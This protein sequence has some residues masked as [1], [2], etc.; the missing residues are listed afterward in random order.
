MS[1]PKKQVAEII[2]DV[3]APVLSGGSIAAAAV[4]AILTSRDLLSPPPASQRTAPPSSSVQAQAFAPP[5]GAQVMNDDGT[6]AET[7]GSIGAHPAGRAPHL[8]SSNDQPIIVSLAKSARPHTSLAASHGQ[9]ASVSVATPSAAM[10][11]I[12]QNNGPGG[13]IVAAMRS[14]SEVGALAGT[15]DEAARTAAEKQLRTALVQKTGIGNANP[16]GLVSDSILTGTPGDD[17]LKGGE[18]DDT[19]SG[20]AGDDVLTGHGGDDLIDAGD[21]DDTLIGGAGDDRLSGGAG[22]DKLIGGEG[23]DTLD[24][25]AGNDRILAGDEDSV[26]GGAGDDRIEVAAEGGPARSVDGGDGD[27]TLVLSGARAG[28]LGRTAVSNVEH[29]VVES[30]DWALGANQPYVDI[31]VKSGAR[32]TDAILLKGS[33]RLVVEAGGAVGAGDGMGV[34]TTGSLTGA[35]IDNSGLITGISYNYFGPIG[36]GP[37]TIVNRV[38]GVIKSPENTGAALKLAGE[39]AQTAPAIANHGS[40]IGSDH[41]SS[42]AIDFESVTGTGARILNEAGGVI[43]TV[44]YQDVIRGGTG[45]VVENHGTIRSYRDHVAEDGTVRHGGDA[46]DYK[47]KTGGLVHNYGGGLIE[48]SRHAVTGKKG[49]TVINDAG[50][51]MIGRNGSALNMD[52]DAA[53]ANTARVTNHGLMEGRSA[54]YDDSDGDAIDTDGLLQLDNWGRIAGLGAHGSHD[55]EANVA[56]G[57]AMGGGAITNHVGATIYGWGRAIQVDD[58]ANGGALAAATIYNDGT[59]QGDGHGPAGV[60]AD[61]A[62]LFAARL[63][64]GEAINIVGGFA[65]D[66]TNSA[67]GKIIGGIRLDAGDDN[68][69]NA[70][71]ITATGGS[72]I[73]M[74]SGD[75]RITN[76]GT[77]TGAVSTGDGDDRI[78]NSGTIQG[79]VQLGSGSNTL[80]NAGTIAGDVAGGS[81]VDEITL[82]SGSTTVGTV[83]LGEGSDTLTI[84]AGASLKTKAASAVREPAKVADIPAFSQA[85]GGILVK[86]NTAQSTVVKSYSLVYD[87]LVKAGVQSYF[88]FLQTDLTNRSDEDLCLKAKDPKFGGIGINGDYEGQLT[89]GAW[90][91]V[92]FTITDR[93]DSVLIKKYIDGVFVGETVQSGANYARYQLDMSK[94]ILL[95]ADE[96]GETSKGAA[97]RF[98]F[99]DTVLSDA[100]IKALG[101]A[102]SDPILK[103]PPSKNSVQ[104]DFGTAG[105]SDI[106][107]QGSAS[108]SKSRGASDWGKNTQS[109]EALG[110]PELKSTTA[111][112]IVDAYGKAVDTG[113][114]NDKLSNSGTV[115]GDVDMGAGDDALSITA[116]GSITGGA[117]MGTGKDTLTNAGSMV[118]KGGPAVDMGAG[119]DTLD[120]GGTIT[121][122]VL[123]GEGDDKLINTGTIKGL[124]SLGAG[125]DELTN[126]GL[127]EGA[128]HAVTATGGAMIINDSAGTLSARN[129]SAISATNAAGAAVHVTNRGKIE[130]RTAD[131][132]DGDA[133]AAID[134]SGLADI[135][136]SGSIQKFFSWSHSRSG[137]ATAISIGGGVIR[138]AQGATIYA[139]GRAIAVDDTKGGAAL[140]ATRII[141]DGT[142]SADGRGG[143]GV[144]GDSR[145]Y[146]RE[147]INLIGD[148]ND[149]ITN[150]ATGRINAG[151]AMGGGDDKLENAGSIIANGLWAVDMGDG[152]DSIANTGS[153][154]GRIVLG[155]GNDTI[156][157]RRQINGSINGG[158]GAD[159]L[160]NSGTIEYWATSAVDLGDGNDRLE[161]GGRINGKVLTGAGDDFVT[162][163][164]SIAAGWGVAIEMGD[165]DDKLTLSGTI[166]GQVFMGAGNDTAIVEAGGSISGAI[167]G[168]DGVDRLVNGGRIEAVQAVTEFAV[169]LGAGDDV[170]NNSG[171]IK[172][173]VTTGDGA[174]EVINTSTGAIIGLVLMEAGNDQLGNSGKITATTGA[175]IDMGDGDDVVKLYIGSDIRGAILLGAGNDRLTADTYL[176][177]AIDVDAGDGNDEVYSALGDDIIHGG[178]GNDTVY[179]GDGADKLYGDAG[180]DVLHGEAGDDVLDGGAGDDVIDGGAGNDTIDGGDGEDMLDFSSASGRISVDFR[181]GTASGD[182]IGID[183][184]SHIEQARLGAQGGQID[185]G[186]GNET[187]FGGGGS[188]VLNGGAGDDRL[189][190][191]SAVN[192]LSGGSGNDTLIAGDKG[193]TLSGGSGD[194]RLNGGAGNDTI[195]GGS[196]RDV[197]TGGA[198]DDVLTGGSGQ[199]N[200][201][202]G[203]GSGRDRITDFKASGADH[204]LISFDH[205]FADFAAAMASARQVGA[206]VVFTIDDHTSLTL[207]QTQI[208][209]LSADDFRFS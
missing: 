161:N 138:N 63:K 153:I 118:A 105:W 98:L 39:L 190:G 3:V 112:P 24:G 97:A 25:G 15:S 9:S 140:A 64:G 172:G 103:T 160:K 92:A 108:V 150:G 61:T 40:I 148:W 156:E 23:Q 109:T 141:N 185:G 124:V 207:A 120:N 1:N 194:D 193:D 158:S 79:D 43:E 51:T 37:I 86:L 46:I 143:E 2:G 132:S 52:N 176:S 91:R 81:G 175:A 152:D 167:D 48:G 174:D 57:I 56:E 146:G 187:L 114:G 202:F 47:K 74:G 171:T 30:G 203:A 50:A 16:A 69:S 192:T 11:Q 42:I 113:A 90:H 191:G 125:K 136:N 157:N 93:G 181:T 168:G 95:F 135:E 26:S 119:D 76:S 7:V 195:S 22:D 131:N 73:D 28:S 200:F 155:A 75:D 182:G 34:L 149:R 206:D 82:K 14:G 100:A 87:V 116:T 55:G 72:A 27:D 164:G 71:S 121:G 178:A 5:P 159:T 58:S 68:L 62:A 188:S 80:T 163:S 142:I 144:T 169:D 85:D 127:I 59:I 19:I 45:T 96:D 78:V 145:L 49:I 12:G 110:L 166:T 130:A 66:V 180:N 204:D 70:G 10:A 128:G 122:A 13:S 107:G 20:L 99:T 32:T 84:E 199:D 94:G 89:Y 31:H 170:I 154:L 54:G 189:I 115:A 41:A 184:F 179:A 197:I 177:T 165:G 201:V 101:G 53:V 133:S 102:S 36:R 83:S 117:L 65:D 33:Q 129:G 8:G 173:T 198:G 88:S 17:V 4:Q 137:I 147:A 35:S 123:M 44:A 77:I 38:G 186:D 134:I 126:S 196:G 104:I 209:S 151:I 183:R 111:A 205:V 208:G 139:S 29:L 67:T 18:G 106:Y 6:E 21:G 60:D 162:N